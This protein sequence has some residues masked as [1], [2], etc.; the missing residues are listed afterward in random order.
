MSSHHFV[1][2]GQEPALFI[3]DAISLATVEPLLEWAPLVMVSGQAAAH[4][5]A[6]GIKIDVA[7]T[8]A[9]MEEPLKSM[10]L[11]QGP[12][13]MLVANAG[14]L[15]TALHF[16]IDLKQPGV[17]IVI[18]NP[19]PLFGLLEHFLPQ[20][21]INLVTPQLKWSGIASG[22]Y[23]KWFPAKSQLWLHSKAPMPAVPG[24]AQAGQYYEV[25]K[26]GQV[27]IAAEWPFWVGETL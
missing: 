18:N 9:D 7:V 23:K 1:K 21:N 24:L 11:S 20:L 2:E 8:P 16:L 10:L 25:L 3:V 15:D 6:W 26:D 19:T 22:I 27:T 12:I 5:L 14:D 17:S 13:K 4:V